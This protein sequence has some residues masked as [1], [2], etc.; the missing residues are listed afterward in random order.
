MSG[1]YNKRTSQK[2]ITITDLGKL[3]V[4]KGWKQAYREFTASKSIKEQR[5]LIHNV[6]NDKF[7]GWKF[8]LMLK[9]YYKVLV[10]GVGFDNVALS[11]ANNV[12]HVQIVEVNEALNSFE[13]ERIKSR[14]ITNISVAKIESYNKL[15][16]DL[17]SFDIVI[18]NRTLKHQKTYASKN[19]FIEAGRVLKDDGQLFFI[20]ANRFDYE[21]F[22]G[23]RKK[24]N[25]FYMLQHKNSIVGYKASLTS[26]GFS[27]IRYFALYP[28]YERPSQVFDLNDSTWGFACRIHSSG[29]KGFLQKQLS[30]RLGLKYTGS[31]FGIVAVKSI[32]QKALVESIVED[33]A[34]YIDKIFFYEKEAIW[35]IKRYFITNDEKIMLNVHRE[36]NQQKEYIVKIPLNSYGTDKLEKNSHIL[37]RFHN[38]RI[39]N[40]KWLPLLPQI[41]YKGE[42]NKQCYYVEEALFAKTRLK[43]LD[44]PQVHKQ[45]L[46]KESV[47]FLIDLQTKKP[48]R[49]TLNER[50]IQK[51]FIYPFLQTSR[52]CGFNEDY[53]VIE[54]LVKYQY[55]NLLGVKIPLVIYHGDFGLHNVLV[56]SASLQMTAIIDWDRGQEN[57]LPMLDLF[58]L[59]IFDGRQDVLL[60]KYKDCLFPGNYSSFQKEMLEYYCN[61]LNIPT[62]VYTSLAIRYWISWIYFFLGTDQDIHDGWLKQMFDNVL[63]YWEKE[64]SNN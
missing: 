14:K 20:G 60:Q 7:T 38:D 15:P 10:L 11:I 13:R 28:D 61:A 59:L 34:A 5:F 18:D 19:I 24:Q 58:H 55:K 62:Q 46:V 57:S 42:V 49:I 31:V 2:E 29:I 52:Y 1:F 12:Q 32:K 33:M 26:C 50:T 64:L 35:N 41:F 3:A 22:L 9:P 43:I 63:P 56:D 39:I 25:P 27:K 54:K 47:D 23:K 40:E 16:F 48:K 8:I 53:P 6:R 17:H 51:Y 30:S 44:I 36:S 37:N 4:Q 21:L 45:R